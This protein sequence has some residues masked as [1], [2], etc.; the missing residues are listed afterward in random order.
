MSGLV[1]VM[2]IRNSNHRI[3]LYPLFDPLSVGYFHKKIYV[4]FFQPTNTLGYSFSTRE[5][6]KKKIYII[7][8]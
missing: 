2:H 7:S 3:K 4:G 8:L 6:F 5:Y 1:R